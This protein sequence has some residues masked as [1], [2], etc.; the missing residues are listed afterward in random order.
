ML[1]SGNIT[2]WWRSVTYGYCKVSRVAERIG[3]HQTAISRSLAGLVTDRT[4]G[5]RTKVSQT[6]KRSVDPLRTICC[7]GI[8]PPVKAY[9]TLLSSVATE[10]GGAR[11]VTDDRNATPQSVPRGRR[12]SRLP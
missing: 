9:V 5:S 3:P 12:D 11:S 6:P 1:L 2:R 4:A 10:W 8:E 7:T